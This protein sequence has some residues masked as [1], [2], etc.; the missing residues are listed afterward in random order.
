MIQSEI[1][2]L[3]KDAMFFVGT[4]LAIITPVLLII[5][6]SKLAT[7]PNEILPW[8]MSCC[9]VNFTVLSILSGLIITNLVQKEYQSCTLTNIL[10]SSTSRLAFI[11]SKLIVWFLWYFIMLIF[12]G[13]ITVLGGKLIYPAQFN[14]SF[15]KSTIELF[16][17]FGLLNFISS[18]PLLWITILQKKLFYP[19]ILTAIGFTA[20]LV[21][22]ISISLEMLLP[23][24]FI[25][26]TAVSIIAIY[27]NGSPCMEIG[28]VSIILTGLIGLFLSYCSFIRQDQ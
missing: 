8:V 26:W 5:K 11:F 15:V 28:M 18:I 12:I 1:L 22:G 10:I 2:K 4:M 3:K 21:G 23:A 20:I 19:S 9:L 24:S 14:L 27:H 7:P 6:D 17:R 16:V 13:A 25:P